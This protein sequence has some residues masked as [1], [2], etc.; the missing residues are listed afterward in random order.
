MSYLFIMKSYKQRNYVTHQIKL[1]SKQSVK[2]KLKDEEKNWIEYPAS[3]NVR[4][5][6]SNRGGVNE[7]AGTRNRL[8]NH[9]R[10]NIEREDFFSREN[11]FFNKQDRR[12]YSYEHPERNYHN[13][14]FY[15]EPREEINEYP[16]KN[17]DEIQHHGNDHRHNIHLEYSDY[18]NRGQYE[19]PF[20][21]RGVYDPRQ[22]KYGLENRE[23]DLY[24]KDFYKN[25]EYQS[26]GNT[27]GFGA[28]SDAHGQDWRDEDEY[29]EGHVARKRGYGKF[30][31]R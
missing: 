26:L 5:L 15:R 23:E 28:R 12:M 31:S 20:H 3:Q 13:P 21:A 14:E 22:N 30:G 11:E 9:E 7:D 27:E 19:R 29:H 6:K 18:I 25:E 2:Q 10:K 16:N 17:Y 4:T 24:E 8:A 1:R